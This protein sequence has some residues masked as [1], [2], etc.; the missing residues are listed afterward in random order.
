[1]I[2][3]DYSWKRNVY[4]PTNPKYQQTV[5]QG[6]E[7]HTGLVIDGNTLIDGTAAFES[8]YTELL[9]HLQLYT[10]KYLY[11]LRPICGDGKNEIYFWNQKLHCCPVSR[12]YVC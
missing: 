3:F 7:V 10:Q 11:G 1:M 6:Y 2:I 5:K 12:P 9:F 8:I 4:T